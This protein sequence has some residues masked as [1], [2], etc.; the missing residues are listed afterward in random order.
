MFSRKRRERRV[1]AFRCRTSLRLDDIRRG[2]SR[3]SIV[4]PRPVSIL[5]SRAG[6]TYFAYLSELRATPAGLQYD[7]TPGCVYVYTSVSISADDSA[8]VLCLGTRVDK[9]IESKVVRIKC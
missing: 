8:T 2:S 3:Q 9:K 1:P 6:Y 5:G 4:G 7:D